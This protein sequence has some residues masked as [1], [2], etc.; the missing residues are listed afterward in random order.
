[1]AVSRTWTDSHHPVAHPKGLD[2]E[3]NSAIM[4]EL[5]KW[6]D[7]SLSTQPTPQNTLPMNYVIEL[8]MAK[9]AIPGRKLVN[10]KCIL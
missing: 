4:A 5:S 7:H 3:S 6:L 10:G 8:W 2:T 1:M 9:D